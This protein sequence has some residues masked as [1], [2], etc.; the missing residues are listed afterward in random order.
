VVSG[1]VAAAGGGGGESSSPIAP[2]GNRKNPDRGS[3]RRATR[4]HRRQL[5]DSW[6]DWSWLKLLT[7]GRYVSVIETL[8]GRFLTGNGDL[9]EGRFREKPGGHR[10]RAQV[11]RR[12]TATE[13]RWRERRDGGGRRPHDEIT[14]P[15]ASRR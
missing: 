12:W 4:S 13:F 6:S 14:K 10:D 11:C 8:R 5:E 2:G 9:D 15:I 7:T 1:A 3:A